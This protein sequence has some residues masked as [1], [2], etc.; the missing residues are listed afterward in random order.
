MIYCFHLIRFSALFILF[1]FIEISLLGCSE[2]Q[3]NGTGSEAGETELALVTFLKSD[4]TPLAYNR[5]QVWEMGVDGLMLE[6]SGTLNEKGEVELQRD[7]KKF[8]LIE[9][10]SGD[11]ISA[12]QWIKPGSNSISITAKK[13]ISLKGNIFR[14]GKALENVLVQVLDKKTVTDSKGYFEFKELPKGIHYV[15]IEDQEESRVLQMNTE[16]EAGVSLNKIDLEENEFISIENFEDWE[17]A[18]TLLGKSF[19]GGWWY[20]CT[21]SLLG[22]NSKFIQEEVV[23]SDS[24]DGGKSLHVIFDLD[25][26]TEN[27]YGVAGFSIGDDFDENGN[28]SFFDL[29]EASAISFRAKGTGEIYLQILKRSEL[30]ERDYLN[31]N[32]IVLTE[33]W[34]NYSISAEDM[35]IE[36]TD[37]NSIN[38]MVENDA[39]F[40]LDDIKIE[41][42][43]VAVW[44]SL[45]LSF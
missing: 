35:G 7:L 41:G 31:S 11:S 29:R 18:Q 15:R 16:H 5:Y 10:R 3:A 14:N 36:F 39:E 6:E 8:R 25:E 44:P 4:G 1:C 13:S 24:S 12:M 28:Y 45:N 42:I 19:G 20:I 43:S 30:G 21:D 27:H 2:N 9:T 34:A 38:F 37:I 23:E 22:G 17:H 40:Y 32:P 33:E 26:E